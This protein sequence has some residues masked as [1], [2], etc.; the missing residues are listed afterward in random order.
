MT[1][2]A[3]STRRLPSWIE[4]FVSYT[5]GYN[6]PLIFRRWAAICAVSAVLERKVWVENY[7]GMVYPNLYVLLVGPPG[8]GKGEALKTLHKVWEGI[9]DFFVASST[10]SYAS[11]LDELKEAHRQVFSP[12]RGLL[13]DFHSLQVASLEFGNLMAV[14]DNTLM[15][16]L[17]QWYDCSDTDFSESRR[18]RA[19]G[20]EFKQVIKNSQVGIIAGTTPDFLGSFLP[21]GAWNQGFCA[22][23][24]M[25]YSQEKVKVT[26]WS[27]KIR[28]K[29][30]FEDLQHDLLII[31][32]RY[33]EVQFSL[34]A[35]A[36]LQRWYDRGEKPEPTHPKLFH[37]RSRR[38]FQLFKLCIIFAMS[39]GN[40]MIVELVDFYAALAEL[41]A[42]EATMPGIFENMITSADASAQLDTLHFILTEY[43]K[44]G[45]VDEHRIINFIAHKTQ[46]PSYSVLKVLEMM[47][48]GN[49]IKVHAVGAQ[50]R[51]TFVPC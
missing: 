1:E 32:E 5:D 15:N 37:Y 38:P 40:S 35:K 48:R 8:V 50:G 47:Q 9:D 19:K 34:E 25:V 13:A 43:N 16:Y 28:S 45:P 49:L 23:T 17:Q 18:G 14:Y 21:E 51:N 4:S 10:V 12:T 3:G 2:N 46:T 6:S 24:I 26:F 39:R 29:K 33:G 41:E 27:E 31:H 30:L 36:A 42:A 22:R 11:M 7:L 20:K 44:T